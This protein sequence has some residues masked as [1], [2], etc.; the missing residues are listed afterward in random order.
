MLFEKNSFNLT[1][2][3]WKIKY[4]ILKKQNDKGKCKM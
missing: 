2:I 3:L 4:Q 1:I